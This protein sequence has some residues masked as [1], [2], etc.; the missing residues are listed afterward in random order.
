MTIVKRN[1]HFPF[2]FDDFFNRQYNRGMADYSNTNTTIPA[3]NIKESAE[4]FVIE[5]A[6]PGMNKKDFNVQVDGNVLTIRSE[7][8]T[9]KEDANNEKY[10]TREFSYQSFVRTFNLPKDIADTDKIEAKYEDGVLHVLI[11]K[12]EKEKVKESRLV[13]V[14]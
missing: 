5:V 1:G 8:T 6:A 9:E 7:K 12:K 14:V 3:V 11:P 10:T 13:E 4:N 2:I